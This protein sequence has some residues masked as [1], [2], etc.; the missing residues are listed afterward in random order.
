MSRR[1][2]DI[3]TAAE[4]AARRFLVDD[5]WPDCERRALTGNRDTGDLTVCRRPLIVAE[6]KAGHAADKASPKVIADWIEQTDTEAVHAG[7]V[8][9]VLIV[10]RKY[11]NPR[12]WD[13]Y[14][15]ACDW[16]LLLSGDEVLW[17][18]APWPMRASLAD[19]SAMAKAWADGYGGSL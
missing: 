9:G 15:R 13:A 3:G 14:M 11:R 16:V 8:L 19:W 18:D 1:P 17:P 12:D 4:T 6:V 5:G 2:K 10:A 7:A